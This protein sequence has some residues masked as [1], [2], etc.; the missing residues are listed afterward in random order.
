MDTENSSNLKHFQT[1]IKAAFL[2]LVKEKKLRVNL[3][4]YLIWND[5]YLDMCDKIKNRTQLSARCAPPQV[6]DKVEK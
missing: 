4:S 1:A 2:S 3:L 5:S 6:V